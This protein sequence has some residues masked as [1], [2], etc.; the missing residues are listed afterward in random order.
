MPQAAT[1]QAIEEAKP[2]DVPFQEQVALLAYHLWEQRGCPD[3]S[4][5]EDWF[6]AERE[7]AAKQN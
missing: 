6:R 1:K 7:L 4:P 5:E 3:G 2:F